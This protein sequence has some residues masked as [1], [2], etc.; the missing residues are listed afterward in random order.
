MAHGRFNFAPDN[1][2]NFQNSAWMQNTT[3]DR[4]TTPHGLTE[5]HLRRQKINTEMIA[6]TH[7]NKHKYPFLDLIQ[8]FPTGLSE[9]H[10]PD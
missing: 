5:P 8:E 7:T 2:H 10:A 9:S 3:S 4:T 6:R 1:S